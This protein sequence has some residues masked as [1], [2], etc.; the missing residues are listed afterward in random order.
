MNR[1]KRRLGRTRYHRLKAGVRIFVVLLLC[2][3]VIGVAVWDHGRR[4]QDGVVEAEDADSDSVYYNG[5][6]YIP[7]KNLET[8]LL[9]GEDK[10]R[11][12]QQD[13]SYINTRQADFLLLLMM[14]RENGTCQA[15]QLN[16]DTMTQ[17]ESYG[18]AGASAGTFEG[19]L[20][21]AHTYGSGGQDSCRYQARAVS[22]LLY[23]VPIDHFC[24]VTM[25]AVAVVNDAVGG[26]SVEIMDDMTMVDPS[27]VQGE[28]VTLEGQLALKYVRNRK[29]LDDTTNL[30]RMERQRQYMQALYEKLMA[31]V[32]SDSGFTAR[33]LLAVNDYVTS[34]CSVTQL[35]ALADFL[36]SCDMPSIDTIDGEN[37]KGEEF[38]EFYPDEDQLRQYVM[39]HF[40]LKDDSETE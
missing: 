8:L 33:L 37:V 12:Q 5:S 7:K 28:T 30:H 38:M 35:Q 34:D 24:S 13:L 14:D 9:I 21:L 11:D 26:V 23:G 36:T 32:G 17:I 29:E 2:A 40:Y 6:R 25:D 27:F 22:N 1:L 4:N 18:V 3:G 20:A 15:L 31:C 10:F 16:R 19:Q 39:D